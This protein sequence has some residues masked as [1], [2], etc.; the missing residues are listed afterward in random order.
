MN[1]MGPSTEPCGT[2]QISCTVADRSVPS[3]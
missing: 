1:K 3:G 2:P